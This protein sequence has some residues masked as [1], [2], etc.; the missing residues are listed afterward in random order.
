MF[1]CNI[2]KNLSRN[3]FTIIFWKSMVLLDYIG[4]FFTFPNTFDRCQT[5]SFWFPSILLKKIR[6][7]TIII[8]GPSCLNIRA[9]L[10]RSELSGTRHSL[11]DLSVWDLHALFFIL[12]EIR[13]IIQAF[14][15]LSVS[16]VLSMKS[17]LTYCFCSNLF[18][19]IF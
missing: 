16:H 14:S 1:W 11:T 3:D 18:Q 15:I 9:E 8:D 10:S 19:L 5:V 2:C 17:Q 6:K 4:I 12:C 13:Q 7:T